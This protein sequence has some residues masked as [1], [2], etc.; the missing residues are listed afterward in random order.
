MGCNCGNKSTPKTYSAFDANG[1]KL[2]N[3]YKT[4][5]EAAAAAKRVGGTYRPN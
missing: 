3:S 4:E 1:K 2:P 5:V